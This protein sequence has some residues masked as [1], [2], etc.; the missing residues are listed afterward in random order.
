VIYLHVYC[1]FHITAMETCSSYLLAVFFFVL[2][3]VN[4]A[5]SRIEVQVSSLLERNTVSTGKAA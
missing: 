3:L 1:H 5:V 4:C 2:C